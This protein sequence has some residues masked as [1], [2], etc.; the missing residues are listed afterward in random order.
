MEFYI[1]ELSHCF[2]ILRCICL[3]KLPFVCQISCLCKF[4]ANTVL[5]V[6]INLLKT[7]KPPLLKKLHVENSNGL[8][9]LRHAYFAQKVL[10][11]FSLFQRV[12]IL[13]SLV[14]ASFIA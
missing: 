7:L 4:Y 3:S 11:F 5:K 2:N 10:H 12:K 14:N 8:K 6:L 13:H 9:T 1:I